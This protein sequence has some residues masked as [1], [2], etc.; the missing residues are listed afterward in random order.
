MV[1]VI[2]LDIFNMIVHINWGSLCQKLSVL[3]TK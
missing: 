3:K 2:S 1:I